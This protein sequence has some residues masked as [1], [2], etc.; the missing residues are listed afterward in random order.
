M[1]FMY[2]LL[3]LELGLLAAAGFGLWFLLRLMRRRSG[4][5]AGGWAALEAA[6]GVAMPPADPITTR[7]SIAVG[8]VVWRNCV[9]VGCDPR[10][11]HLAV[12][13]PLLGG[14]GKKPV[15]IP[16]DAFHDPEAVKLYWQ[17]AHL[18]HLGT[19]EVATITLPADLETHLHAEGHTL[20]TGRPTDPN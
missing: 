3:A 2:A 13:V 1:N 15:R 4:H 14:F 20:G 18:W 10:G 5:A 17:D 8:R 11:L 16:W 9:V 12:R 6:W 7:A 19:P